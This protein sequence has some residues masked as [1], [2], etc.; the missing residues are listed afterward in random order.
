[1]KIKWSLDINTGAVERSEAARARRLA[2][3]T[4]VGDDVIASTGYMKKQPLGV[5]ADPNAASP[6]RGGSSVGGH[7]ALKG[8]AGPRA[9]S[10]GGRGQLTLGW[11][12]RG[13]TGPRVSCPGG[14]IYG[15]DF[16]PYDTGVERGANV[17]GL[18]E[19]RILF[20]LSYREKPWLRD[21]TARL[22]TYVHAA[23]REIVV[24]QMHMHSTGKTNFA[25]LFWRMWRFVR[26]PLATPLY[27]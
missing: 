13:T 23:S 19:R 17:R 11:G 21:W 15:R 5:I 6:W 4:V 8:T 24:A 9:A 18:A 16:S 7:L 3:A 25:D 1:M 10:P 20:F 12:V 14:T 27:I 22:P 26:T 2:G